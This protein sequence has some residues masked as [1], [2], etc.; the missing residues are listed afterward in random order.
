M[1]VTAFG[2]DIA[3]VLVDGRISRKQAGRVGQILLRKVELTL[4]KVHPPERIDIR[5]VSR[6][7]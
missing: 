5:P 2:E 7:L 1:N 3:Q 6:L 4:L